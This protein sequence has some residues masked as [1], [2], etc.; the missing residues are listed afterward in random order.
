MNQ[1]LVIYK[2]IG[3]TPKQVLDQIRVEQPQLSKEKMSYMGRLDPMAHGVMLVLCGEENKNREKYKG[4]DKKYQ[5]K[6]LFG[7]E[8]DSYDILGIPTETKLRVW[9]TKDEVRTELV[10]FVGENDQ[11]Y[12]PFSSVRVKG[13]AL[14][15]WARIGYL[16]QIVIPRHKV[17]VASLEFL[18]LESL[19]TVDLRALVVKRLNLIKGDF[20]QDRILA[21]WLML[22]E[23][24]DRSEWQVASIE[25]NCSSGTYVRSI[26][27]ELGK[28]LNVGGITLEILR[29]RV[30]G[31]TLEKS[32]PIPASAKI[33]HEFK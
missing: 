20:R 3:L 1:V 7:V 28:K 32:L 26:A 5:F 9:V 27:D 30:G 25:I 2:P 31:Y 22:L 4:L 11:K 21:D 23:K 6:I 29:T 19:S 17:T 24:S 10:N 13:K 15:E 12:P 14:F 18:K 33:P 8:T 16:E